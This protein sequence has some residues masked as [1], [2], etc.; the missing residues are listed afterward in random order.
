[1]K[2]YYRQTC[3]ICGHV[4]KLPVQLLGY[5]VSCPDCRVW[6]LAR[7][8]A[9]C[10]LAGIPLEPVELAQRKDRR[11]LFDREG[12]GIESVVNVVEVVGTNHSPAA[13]RPR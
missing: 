6:F 12:Q 11:T 2:T 7:D 1:M 5:A 8:H 4:F 9:D 13:R 3:P 10:G